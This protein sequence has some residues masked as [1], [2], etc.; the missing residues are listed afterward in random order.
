MD[1]E[2]GRFS[3][4]IETM[5]KLRSPDGCPWD[6]KQDYESLRPH[7]IEEAYEL[8][9]AIERRETERNMKHVLEECGDLLLQVIFIGTIAEEKGDFSID[10]IPR[11]ITEKLIRRHPHIFGPPP[12]EAHEGAPTSWEEIKRQ[13]R[14]AAQT[15]DVSVL[16]GVPRRL[17]ALTKACRIQEKAAGVGFDWPQGE[18]TPVVEK[19]K[20]EL[21]KVCEVLDADKKQELTGEIGDLLFAVVN[22]SRRCGIDPDLALSR[23]NAKFERRFRYIETQIEQD[24]KKW[25]DLSLNDLIYLWNQAKKASL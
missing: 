10:D 23:T 25:N 16:T 22:L 24:G 4:L 7:I 9:D 13:E 8:V 3:E 21:V 19:I 5:K 1:K 15:R 6:R 18:Q 11:V 2:P 17:P 14:Q 12:A 20:E